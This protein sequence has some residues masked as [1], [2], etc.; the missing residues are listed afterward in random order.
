MTG[1]NHGMTGAVIAL[2]VKEPALAVPLSFISH[3][4]CDSIPHFGLAP[5]DKLFDRKFNVTLVM[6][7]LVAVSL[8]VILGLM[9]R[10][11][12]WLIW[13]CMVAAASPDLAWA[14]YHLY[15]QK[16]KK[17]KPKFDRLSRF[18]IAIQWSQTPKG[19]F[20]EVAWFVLIG[21][22]ILAQR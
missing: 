3:F 11:Q 15:M 16:I 5:N 19:W 9:F 21:S 1:T 12:R 4:A 22:I 7:F 6:D 13:A 18:H 8:M 2:L 14:Y 20:V 17:R 10:S